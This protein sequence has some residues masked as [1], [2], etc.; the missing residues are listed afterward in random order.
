MFQKMSENT[1][2]YP[3]I[4]SWRKSNYI[5]DQNIANIVTQWIDFQ[6]TLEEKCPSIMVENHG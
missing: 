5:E 6:Q 3:K 2:T 1:C 4:K